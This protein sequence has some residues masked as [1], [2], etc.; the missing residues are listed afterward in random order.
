MLYKV[1]NVKLTNFKTVKNCLN[2]KSYRMLT[3]RG[4]L[5]LNP[6]ARAAKQTTRAIDVFIFFSSEIQNDE[7]LSNCL[8][9]D[10]SCMQTYL[11]L[12]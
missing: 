3:G 12:N 10:S 9:V 7:L 6:D 4:P 5:R 11:F 8:E 2:K 1:P